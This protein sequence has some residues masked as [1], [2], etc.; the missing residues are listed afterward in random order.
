MPHHKAPTSELPGLWKAEGIRS[1]L[2][3]CP[4]RVWGVILGGFKTKQKIAVYG[5]TTVPETDATFLLVRP[6]CIQVVW[7]CM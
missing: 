4:E 6:F 5:A 2:S 1:V 3:G 7:E